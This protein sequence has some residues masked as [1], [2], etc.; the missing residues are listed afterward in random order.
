MEE[1]YESMKEMILEAEAIEAEEAREMV[2][3]GFTRLIHPM[4]A[5]Q[6]M[7]QVNSKL[8]PKNITFP[9]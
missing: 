6:R 9:W 4:L 3:K 7:S 1:V 5:L 8:K 2:A